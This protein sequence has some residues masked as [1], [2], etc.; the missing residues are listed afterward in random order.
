MK[1]SWGAV[2][3]RPALMSL[4]FV[5]TWRVWSGWRHCRDGTV[6]VGDCAREPHDEI[7]E[8]VD[9]S[10]IFPNSDMERDAY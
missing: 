7:H 8:S 9:L 1:Q 4:V 3:G 5:A 10:S 2:A 6:A